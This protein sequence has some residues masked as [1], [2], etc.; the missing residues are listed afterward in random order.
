MTN[1]LSHSLARRARLSSRAILAAI[2]L[3]L[4]AIA[5]MAI[6]EEENAANLKPTGPVSHVSTDG[7]PILVPVIAH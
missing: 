4:A 6:N 7:T 5:A 1:K 3:T 2:A